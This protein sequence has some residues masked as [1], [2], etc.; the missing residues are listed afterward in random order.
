MVIIYLDLK[1]YINTR[2]DN[3]LL[4]LFSFFLVAAPFNVMVRDKLE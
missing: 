1:E 3:T 2:P 4:P